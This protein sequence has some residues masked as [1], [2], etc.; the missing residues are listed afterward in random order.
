MA[1]KLTASRV[2]AVINAFIEAF[3]V[4]DVASH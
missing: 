1:P 2:S 3:S 4:N